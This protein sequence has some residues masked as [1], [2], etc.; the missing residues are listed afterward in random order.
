M[1][2]DK[3]KPFAQIWG[4][5]TALYEQGGTLFDGAGKP[6]EEALEADAP[7]LSTPQED[8]PKKLTP[9]GFL[10][11]ALSGGPVER[12]RLHT[13]AGELGVLWNDVLTAAADMGVFKERRGKTLTEVWSIKKN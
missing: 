4:H 7:P 5:E 12:A 13:Q 2:L 8:S 6:I 11:H 1:K 3:A 10:T 9:R